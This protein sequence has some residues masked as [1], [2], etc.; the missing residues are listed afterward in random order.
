M[1]SRWRASS[2]LM[3][4]SARSRAR[5]TRSMIDSM[6]MAAYQTCSARSPGIRPHPAPVLPRGE[7]RD[8]AAGGLRI[9]RSRARRRTKLAASRLRSHSHGPAVCLVEVVEV[10]HQPPLRAG[11]HPE[12][13]QVGVAARLDD[14][15]GR[16]RR[17]QI[18][19]HDRGRSPQEREGGGDH[20]SDP[21]RH[22]LREPTFIGR[23]QGGDRV[24]PV[25]RGRPA[26]VASARDSAAK[27]QASLQRTRRKAV[28]RQGLG[29]VDWHA[30]KDTVRRVTSAESRQTRGRSPH[31]W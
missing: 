31:S 24:G 26:V 8:V 21:D 11:E 20:P 7:P 10:E 16:G 19:S 4:R 23:H 27:R 29:Q 13:G 14:R 25:R 12:V 28:R 30:R 6:G 1:W 18:G 9:A 3:V 2:I 17:R 22:E 5:S 15:T